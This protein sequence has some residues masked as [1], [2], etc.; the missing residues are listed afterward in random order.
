MLGDGGETHYRGLRRAIGW[1]RKRELI[2]GVADFHNTT[3]NYYCC[4]CYSTTY[5]AKSYPIHH[6]C[7]VTFQH[8]VSF[9]GREN[10][11][12]HMTLDY[13]IVYIASRDRSHSR[14]RPLLR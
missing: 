9:S 7:I 11:V 4:F 10:C 2:Y 13:G 5:H 14:S 12:N 3:T 6:I 1:D 8:P